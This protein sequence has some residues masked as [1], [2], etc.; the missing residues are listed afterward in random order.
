M[1]VTDESRSLRDS[2]Y[3][4][5]SRARVKI[6]DDSIPGEIRALLKVNS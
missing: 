3:V 2:F 5:F 6:S 4:A 1:E